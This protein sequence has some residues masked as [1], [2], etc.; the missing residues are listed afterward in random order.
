MASTPA[1]LVL[2]TL[3]HRSTFLG[4]S[5]ALFKA[6]KEIYSFLSLSSFP[7]HPPPLAV[8]HHISTYPVNDH[9]ITRC[10]DAQT[11]PLWACLGRNVETCMEDEKP[12][13]L[14]ESYAMNGGDGT[15]K[16][17]GRCCKGT[18]QLSSSSTIN[19]FRIADF[20]RSTGPNTLL[21]MQIIL[22]AVERKFKSEKPTTQFVLEF[23]VF[24]SDQ[25]LSDVNTLFQSLPPERRYHAAGVAG[26][27]YDTLFPTAS[28][29]FAFSS[30]SLCWISDLPKEILD[31]KSPAWNKK[32]I[33]Y[34]GGRKEV[35]EA[36]AA[37]YAKDLETFLNPRAEE[38]VG[39][40]LIALLIPI[41]SNVM[42]SS[43][44][45]IGSGI[46]LLGSCL[47]DM[48]KMVRNVEKL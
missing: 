36:Y 13:K 40:G 31:S 42:N 24:F 15:C 21:A 18:H 11:R 7:S 41:V 12:I 4:Y 26:F 9:A 2:Q 20:G 23:Q 19:P 1:Q 22:E 30:S 16:R 44:I 47:M 46:D 10:R 3:Q 33:H 17:K 37:Q 32:R 48:A 43:E 25:V 27:F 38:L 45:T 28:L 14:P 6:V 5:S 29:H 34:T 8:G 39:G 35:Y